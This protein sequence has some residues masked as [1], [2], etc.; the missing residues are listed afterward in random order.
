MGLGAIRA[1]ILITLCGVLL[2]LST[3][4]TSTW[5]RDKECGFGPF[6]GIW[7]ARLELEGDAVSGSGLLS[8]HCTGWD[9]GA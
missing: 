4:R 7:V 3:H 8:Q 1:A 6:M 2:D 5:R 9:E